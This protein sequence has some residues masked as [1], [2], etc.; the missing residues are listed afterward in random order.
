MLISTGLLILSVEPQQ[1]CV[2]AGFQ[3]WPPMNHIS[4]NSCTCLVPFHSESGLPCILLQPV[5]CGRSASFRPKPQEVL[6]NFHFFAFGSPDPT[7]K[8]S[9][10]PVGEIIQRGQRERDREATCRKRETG[11]VVSA[12]PDFQKS[13]ARVPDT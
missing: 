2:V 9:G 12:E 8:K 5:E 6:D 10:Y 7:Y 4:Q 3:R 13:P 11:L 1:G